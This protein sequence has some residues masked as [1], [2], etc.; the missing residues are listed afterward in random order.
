M[1][2]SLNKKEEKFTNDQCPKRIKDQVNMA[3][4]LL[5]A[6]TVVVATAAAAVAV[7]IPVKGVLS[8]KR[9]VRRDI[10]KSVTRRQKHVNICEIRF[11]ASNT[12][13][14]MMH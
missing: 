10:A 13:R 2:I 14:K 5:L 6:V 12:R 11:C 4:I 7:A 8:N 9:E 3:P 1:L